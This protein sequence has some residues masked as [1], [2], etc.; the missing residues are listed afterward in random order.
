MDRTQS[1][2]ALNMVKHTVTITVGATPITIETGYTAKQAAGS[3]IIRAGD[4]MVL[5]TACDGDPRPGLDFFPLTVDYREKHYAAGRFPGNFFRR[6]ARPSEHETLISRL[7]DRPIRPLFPDGFFNEVQVVATVMSYNSE[8]DADIPARERLAEA[9]T[10]NSQKHQRLDDRQDGRDT[11]ELLARLQPP[12]RARHCGG[13]RLV[14]ASWRLERHGHDRRIAAAG[15]RP[16]SDRGSLRRAWRGTCRGTRA[17]RPEWARSAR[18]C[19]R[20]G[21]SC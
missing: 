16:L 2:A 14:H 1:L 13:R 17:P 8:V 7:T 6:E 19:S 21:G 18:S 4:T 3:V 9:R 5:S 12:C 10:K 15:L 20:Q 11:R